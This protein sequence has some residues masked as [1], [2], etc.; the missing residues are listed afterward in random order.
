MNILTICNKEM[1][2]YFRSPIAYT[3]IALW[4]LIGGF[5]FYFGLSFFVQR[6]MESAMTGQS[7]PMNINEWIVRP[8]LSNVNVVALFLIPMIT[9]RLFA[10]EKRSGTIELLMTSPINDLEIVLGKWLA[11]VGLY[12]IMLLVSMLHMSILFRYG[13]PDWRPLLVGYLGLLLQGGCLLA[14]GTFVSTCTSNQIVA[15]AIGFAISLLLF[16]LNWVSEFGSSATEKVIGYLSVQQHFESF[17]KGVIDS[18][19]VIF[20]VT[21]ITLGLFLT[22]RSLESVRWRA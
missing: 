10:E 14:I 18:K 8:L 4:A 22:S 1:Q 17:S 21:M 3:V 13:Q 12:T 5:F 2:S 19:D 7:F 9:M 15:G 6:S 16:V 20:Y 11:A